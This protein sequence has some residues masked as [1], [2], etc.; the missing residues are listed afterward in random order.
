VNIHTR[1]KR[2]K[3]V[4]QIDHNSYLIE[5]ETD[6][7]RFGCEIDPIITYADIEGGPFLHIGKDFFGKGTISNIQNIDSGRNGYIIIRV[8]INEKSN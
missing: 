6:C 2:S 5:G 4:T 8:T 7:V 1:H 3:T